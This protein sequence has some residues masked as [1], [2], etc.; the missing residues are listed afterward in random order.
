MLALRGCGARAV[1]VCVRVFGSQ[2]LA[3]TDFPAPWGA[4]SWALVVFT[5][6][7]GMGSGVVPPPWPPGRL[8]QPRAPRCD[9]VGRGRFWR[10]VCAC[11]VACVRSRVAAAWMAAVRGG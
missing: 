1:C 7:F 8:S 11:A 9:A 2:D 3:A 5:F 10:G 4:V 6:E